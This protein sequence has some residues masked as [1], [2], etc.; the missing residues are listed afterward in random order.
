MATGTIKKQ[1]DPQ[2]I[3]KQYTSTY[4]IA[5]SGNATVSLTDLTDSNNQ[6]FSIPTGYSIAGVVRCTSGDSNI[7]MRG[8]DINSSNGGLYFTN[9]ASSAASSKKASLDVVFIRN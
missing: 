4:S 7:V 6:P 1:Y 3:V 8:Y 2:I 9:L 5:A